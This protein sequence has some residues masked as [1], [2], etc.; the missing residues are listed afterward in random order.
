M[1]RNDGEG[2]PFP[3][4]IPPL[5]Y[6]GF[7]ARINGL[8]NSPPGPEVTLEEQRKLVR[9]RCRIPLYIR[10]AGSSF[11]GQIADIGL[12]GIAIRSNKPLPVDAEVSLRAL[13]AEPEG[14]EWIPARIVWSRQQSGGKRFLAGARL[15]S[16][17]ETPDQSWMSRILGELGL[18][19][20]TGHNR[21]RFLRAQGA[22]PVQLSSSA[23]EARG[24][25]VDLSLEGF[26]LNASGPLQPDRSYSCWLG[27]WKQLS[28]IGPFSAQILRVV[29][30]AS[31]L[32]F[33]VTFGG[34]DS[35][36]RLLLRHYV[37]GLLIA[38]SR[39]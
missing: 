20:V 33:P 4:R 18:D 29:E 39:Q 5:M 7:W 37:I 22:I 24:T 10:H 27:P 34:L 16:T 17:K 11:N 26:L 23:G 38:E 31:E 8:F 30:S 3:T 9:I 21:R 36:E 28:R 25:T 15:H 19:A 12:Q 14:A 32:L 1:S 35:S 6:R 13:L 2:L